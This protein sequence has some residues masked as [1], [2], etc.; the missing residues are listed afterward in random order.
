MTSEASM[1]RWL[2]GLAAAAVGLATPFM[3]IQSSEAA[4]VDTPTTL[5]SKASDRC[6][7]IDG[8]IVADNRQ[9]VVYDCNN[10]RAATRPIPPASPP[11]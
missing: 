5:V 8:D 11:G 7:P 3:I 6:L 2:L 10:S 9:P 4:I 1:R